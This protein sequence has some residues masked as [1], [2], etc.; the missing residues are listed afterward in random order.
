MG[1]ETRELIFQLI[2]QRISAEDFE[3]LQDAIEADPDVRDEYL[4][5]INLC[6]SLADDSFDSLLTPTPSID[7]SNR[8]GRLVGVARGGRWTSPTIQWALAAAVV[9]LVG[10]TAYWLG[11]KNLSRDQR[12]IVAEDQGSVSQDGENQLAGQALAIQES[13]A[14]DL[15][16]DQT[17]SRLAGHATLRRAVDLKWAN[18]ST[19]RREGD[20]LPNGPLV[21]DEGVAEI[22][23]FCGATLI[24]DG[25]AHLEIESDWSVRVA[26]GR[27]RANVPPAA[28]GFIVKAAESEI[29]DLGTEFAL[30][31]DSDNARVEVIDGEVELRGGEHD[32]KHLLTGEGQSLRGTQGGSN[33]TEGL[34]TVSDVRRRRQAAE[35]KQFES[36]KG[37]SDRMRTED[38]LIAYYPIA[39]SQSGRLV[40]NV[41]RRGR[42]LDGQLVG[43]VGVASGR[44]GDESTALEF[45]RLGSRVRTRIDGE[46][47]AFT[48]ACW[49]RIDSLEHRYKR[50]VYG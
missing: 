32:G 39:A 36:W 25:P 28:R 44:F 3:R 43:P 8:T 18:Q 4:R 24:V 37:H 45:D 41:S 16:S 34:S 30:E 12:Q 21:F 19:A 17:E 33:L 26:K 1:D 23:F 6:E 9:V 48:F 5:A 27:L 46:F 11:Q 50:F 10:C 49:A 15:T 13:T 47:G 40:Q 20:V 42:E 35:A 29:V 14:P 38:R 22:D 2:D 7:E 31:V